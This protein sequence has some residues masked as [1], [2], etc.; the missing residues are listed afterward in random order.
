MKK[1]ELEICSASAEEGIGSIYERI[2]IKRFFEALAKQ[3]TFNSV[4][5]Y[6]GLAITKGIDNITFLKIGKDV[7]VADEKIN[8]IQENWPFREKPRF[9]LPHKEQSGFDL[10][11][12]FAVIQLQPEIIEEMIALSNKFVLIFVPN[13]LNWGM[14]AHQLYH[15]L[16][17]TNCQHAEK[18]NLF[19]RTRWGVE[20][21][22]RNKGLKIIETGY[23][24]MPP[25]PDIGF[26]IR[27][28]REKLGL[29]TEFKRKP[30][31]VNSEEVLKRVNR[32]N[33][34]EKLPLPEMI[35]L[36]L[37][38]HLYLLGKRK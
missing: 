25:L 5:E 33:F 2:M 3:Y 27:E 16:T 19:I 35:K 21:L 20:R 7:T 15:F 17:C 28:L 10:V 13:F 31:S 8:Q 1:E 30:S 29:K 24:D 12:N 34:L 26:S 6:Q 18:G 9:S 38:H 23:I 37:A 32:M 14:P 22:A 36:P 4:L 11:W